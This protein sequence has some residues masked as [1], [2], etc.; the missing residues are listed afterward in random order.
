MPRALQ[1]SVKIKP[2][3]LG[4]NHARARSSEFSY[5]GEGFMLKNTS[6]NRGRC[7]GAGFRGKLLEGC[8]D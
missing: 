6:H 1:L 8:R 4:L 2:P 3:G 7:G 5:F